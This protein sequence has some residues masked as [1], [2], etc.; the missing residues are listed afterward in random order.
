MY[1]TVPRLRRMQLER[2]ARRR[3]PQ[4]LR[5]P[6]PPPFLV[7]PG[8]RA[9]DMRLKFIF[10]TRGNQAGNRARL[11]TAQEWPFPSCPGGP[12]KDHVT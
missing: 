2:S 8:H 4:G 7:P 11:F 3:N 9:V 5:L 6:S 1:E 10:N 12:G